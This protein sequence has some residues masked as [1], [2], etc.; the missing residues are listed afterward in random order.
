MKCRNRAEQVLLFSPVLGRDIR[1][2]RV[3]NGFGGSFCLL[4]N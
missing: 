4:L 1:P 2:M 3:E